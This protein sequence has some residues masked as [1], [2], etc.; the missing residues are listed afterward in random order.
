MV[1]R[2]LVKAKTIYLLNFQIVIERKTNTLLAKIPDSQIIATNILDK[3][4]SN[5]S[6][7]SVFLTNGPCGSNT[8]GIK[9]D[10]IKSTV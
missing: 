1:F 3:Q 10:S 5:V 8:G 4:V 2:N 7:S 6:K 9:K